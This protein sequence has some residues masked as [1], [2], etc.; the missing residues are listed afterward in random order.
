MISNAIHYTVDFC[1]QNK[2]T[3]IKAGYCLL[4][5]AGDE[6]LEARKDPK[7]FWGGR[8]RRRIIRSLARAVTRTVRAVTRT[9]RHVVDKVIHY[10]VGFCKKNPCACIRAGKMA[11]AVAAAGDEPLAIASEQRTSKSDHQVSGPDSQDSEG[12]KM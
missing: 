9:V 12:S 3:C 1:R 6:A 8:R 10:T 7:A 5:E 4:V 2:V 11:L